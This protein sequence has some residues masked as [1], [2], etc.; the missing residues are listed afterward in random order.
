MPEPKRSPSIGEKLTADL[1]Q[2]EA[3]ISEELQ[4]LARDTSFI[5]L[6]R[7]VG[8]RQTRQALHGQLL[9]RPIVIDVVNDEQQA[10]QNPVED[11]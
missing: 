6:L 7:G 10:L 8:D 4:A 2:L 5:A 11:R 1:K 9:T 3:G